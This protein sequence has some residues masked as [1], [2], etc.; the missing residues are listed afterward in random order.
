MIYISEIADDIGGAV[1]GREIDVFF[2]KQAD[3]LDWG[4]KPIHKDLDIKVLL[5]RKYLII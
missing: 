4:H 1:D 5:K 2:V 3:T